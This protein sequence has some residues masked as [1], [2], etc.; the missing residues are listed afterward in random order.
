MSYQALSSQED[1][2]APPQ[3][4]GSSHTGAGATSAKSSIP[5]GDVPSYLQAVNYIHVSDVGDI[6]GTVYNIDTDKPPA[7]GR[8]DSQEEQAEAPQ[9]YLSAKDI[10]AT[11]RLSGSKRAKI[12]IHGCQGQ[13]YG[14]AMLRIVC[15]V[16]LFPSSVEAPANECRQR[17]YSRA[18][19]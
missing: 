9:V 8:F 3:Y 18:Y 2:H 13:Q 6:I 5:R 10:Q 19:K 4:N 1:G 7:Y 14:R 11:I 17:C 15:A 16:I 12:E